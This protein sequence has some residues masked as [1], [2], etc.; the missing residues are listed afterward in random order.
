MPEIP[1]Q[2]E[3]RDFILHPS[4]LI[5]HPSFLTPFPANVLKQGETLPAGKQG[6]RIE[7]GNTLD[8]IKMFVGGDDVGELMVVHDGRMQQISCFNT[9]GGILSK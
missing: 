1:L 5:P 3:L 6:L 7:P 9:L 4:S 8:L 2:I